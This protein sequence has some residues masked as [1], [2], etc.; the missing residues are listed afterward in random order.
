VVQIRADALGVPLQRN[1]LP[2]AGVLVTAIVAGLGGATTSALAR[3]AKPACQADRTSGP[4]I[5]QLMTEARRIAV[6]EGPRRGLGPPLGP[7]LIRPLRA[8]EHCGVIQIDE[9]TEYRL[10][11][12][13]SGMPGRRRGRK[14][15]PIVV[16]ES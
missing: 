4:A 15:P 16:I 5:P 7:G 8:G 1:A 14:R 13:A 11:N 9:H 6:S 10:M 3:C 2:E 12:I